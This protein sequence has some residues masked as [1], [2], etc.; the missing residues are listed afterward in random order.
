[1]LTNVFIYNENISVY[2]GKSNNGSL[3]LGL[4]DI[5]PVRFRG[6]SEYFASSS[7]RLP[8]LMRQIYPKL[9]VLPGDVTR[10]I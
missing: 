9:M 10:V 1:M 8:R 5:R 7:L 2:S 6:S 3:L 4:L